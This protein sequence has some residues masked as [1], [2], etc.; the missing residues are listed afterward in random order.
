MSPREYGIPTNLSNFSSY[1]TYS[2]MNMFAGKQLNDL[3]MQFTFTTVNWLLHLAAALCVMLYSS[4]ARFAAR[5]TWF[6]FWS[7][8][9]MSIPVAN[10]KTW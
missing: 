9:H 2:A 1:I 8:R 6:V 5:S 4:V 7:Y 3:H 10:E